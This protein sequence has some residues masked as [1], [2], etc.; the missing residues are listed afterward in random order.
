MDLHTKRLERVYSMWAPIY[1]VVFGPH[2]E[3]GRRVGVE[4]LSLSRGERVLEV[5]F[6]TG[7]TLRYYPDLELEIHGIDISE[8]MLEKGIARAK[9]YAAKSSNRIEIRLMDAHHLEY[10]SSHFDAV[11]CPYVLTVV[12]DLTRVCEE[13][14][15]VLKKGGRLVAVNHAPRRKGVL[16]LLEEKAS[17]LFQRLGFA[18]HIDVED[19]VRESGFKVD[20]RERVGILK[21]Y[22]VIRGYKLED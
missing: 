9:K 6:G 7:L 14:K 22:K 17:P 19:Y 16:R 2:M 18:T 12:P 1:D 20:F 5:G 8:K 3:E 11:F 13:I 21:L 10:P 15:R 4:V